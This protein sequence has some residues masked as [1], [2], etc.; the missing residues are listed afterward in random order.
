MTKSFFVSFISSEAVSTQAMPFIRGGVES[1]PRISVSTQCIGV[2]LRRI[3]SAIFCILH[4]CEPNVNRI[5]VVRTL[6]M[7]FHH[8]LHI[9]CHKSRLFCNVLNF[10]F[11]STHSRSDSTAVKVYVSPFSSH[12]NPTDDRS[13]AMNN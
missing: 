4:S 13:Q 2:H 10:C 12:L 9:R 6:E 7:H 11:D 5:C 8:Y 3:T 1:D